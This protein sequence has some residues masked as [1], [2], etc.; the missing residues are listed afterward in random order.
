MAVLIKRSETSLIPHECGYGCCTP[1]YNSKQAKRI[2]RT[3]KR[4][5]RQQWKREVQNV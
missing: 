5:Q 1:L 2:R 4:A 3:I